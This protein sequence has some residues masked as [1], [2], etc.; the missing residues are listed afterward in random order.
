MGII[1]GLRK[2]G[3]GVQAQSRA[4]FVAAC[5]VPVVELGLKRASEV[6]RCVRSTAKE[7]EL[8]NRG[9]D[10][11]Q[12]AN[13]AFRQPRGPCAAEDRRLRVHEAPG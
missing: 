2:I 9:V 4:P 13:R 3:F 5:P 1:R 11:L 6:L 10:E 12:L 8:I 7:I